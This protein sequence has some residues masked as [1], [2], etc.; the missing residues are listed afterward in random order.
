M[1]LPEYV[2]T[3]A[4][5]I[6]GA[7]TLESGD[8]LAIRVRY[9]ASRSLVW[10]ATGYRFEKH[11][12]IVKSE[13]GSEIIINLPCTDVPG[14]RDPELNV[15][16][17]VAAPGSYTHRYIA[18]V[19]FLDADGRVISRIPRLGPFTVPRG[20]GTI[21]LDRTVAAGTVAGERILVP[22]QWGVL[23]RQAQEAAVAAAEAAS[24]GAGPVGPAGAKGD[25]G[26]RGPQGLQGPQGAP[27]SQGLR[28]PAGEA[29]PKG[30]RGD[31]GPK[32]DKGDTGSQGPAGTAGAAGV[33]GA[34]GAKGDKGD[35]GD[36][37][38]AGAK[39]DKGDPGSGTIYVVRWNGTT[40]VDP[41][42]PAGT[43]IRIFDAAGYTNS[44]PYS[45]A[46][47]TGVTDYYSTPQGA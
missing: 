37:G 44:T 23:V 16:I 12:R 14:W 10:D 36:R 19:E 46:T 3:R 11:E 43:M 45:G 7:A 15:I 35:K 22:D 30:D 2:P 21:D 41:T 42:P 24:S 4:V 33:A 6:G 28:G 9:T 18:E 25:P 20:T 47:V 8:T 39:G 38:D 31:V 34:A 40:W 26:E 5:S 32:G 1:A 13:L 29:G 27:G 17:D